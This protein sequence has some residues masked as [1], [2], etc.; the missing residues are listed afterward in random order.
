MV[1]GAERVNW[2]SV[3]FSFW[4]FLICK[5]VNSPKFSL[6]L[7]SLHFLCVLDL[8]KQGCLTC[9]VDQ[10]QIVFPPCYVLRFLSVLIQVPPERGFSFSCFSDLLHLLQLFV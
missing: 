7:F 3:F 8:G 1:R 5:E 4:D 10:R 6:Y 2:D 9:S